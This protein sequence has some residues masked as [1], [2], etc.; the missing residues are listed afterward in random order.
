MEAAA[1]RRGEARQRN[2][3]K[4]HAASAAGPPTPAP[5]PAP[6]PPSGPGLE[7]LAR[8]GL[9]R[10]FKEGIGAGIWRVFDKL[11]F[12]IAYVGTAVSNLAHLVDLN[13]ACR[14]QP[15]SPAA[16]GHP[17]NYGGRALHYPY[18]PIRPHK[19]WKPS[20]QD[21]GFP[22]A[23]DLASD[24]ASFP[25]GE[26]RDALVAAYFC[27]V[28]PFLPVVAEPWFMAAYR[29]PDEPPPLLLF[30]AVLM[31]GAHSCTHPLVARDRH[32]V[33]SIIFRRAALLFH[34]R[35]ETDRAHLMQAA[36]LFTWHVGDGDTITAGPWYWAGIALRIA[37]GMGMH[38]ASP[39]LPQP[40]ASHQR[41]C[42][43]LA[44]ICEVLSALETGR[45]CSI[46]AED[47]DQIMLADDDMTSYP[48]DGLKDYAAAAAAAGTT[49]STA[50]SSAG[51]SPASVAEATSSA[52]A[53]ESG[54]TRR[55]GPNATFLNR[56]VELCYIGLDIL[57]LSAPSQRRIV[58]IESIDVRL[59]LWSLRA[60]IN[61]SPHD[62][63]GDRSGKVAAEAA[64][65]ASGGTH[66]ARP[67]DG[68][69]PRNEVDDDDDDD[70]D[71]VA[72]QC[73]LRMHYNL[74]LLHLHR[75][76]SYTA[77]VTPSSPS[78]CSGAARAIITS[79]ERL[80]TL[81]G[82]LGRCHFS[83]VSAATAAA[84]QTA[85][86]VREAA[87]SRGFIVVMPALEQLARL[88]RVT[89]RLAKHWPNAQAVHDVF[90]ELHHEYETLVT[91]GLRGEE[92]MIRQTQPDWN[93]LLGGLQ[94]ARL[95]GLPTEQEWLNM[96]D[97][98]L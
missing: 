94:V 59:G 51:R 24:V 97:G 83:A 64:A 12:H 63:S 19:S 96:P 42:W 14:P 84:I 8:N 50:T 98:P 55:G 4:T 13:K 89:A 36:L 21:W 7:Q 1:S 30:Q 82:G 11:D 81:R 44:F 58:D 45:P 38:R 10:F 28:H 43:W 46:S 65:A 61:S 31:A 18:P 20:V 70:T 37:C 39:V 9:V 54:S 29:T 16:A 40:E 23:E 52:R 3:N 93:L 25:V 71:A 73:Q 60:G 75:S 74:M 15:L 87:L 2:A 67:G 17:D 27:D 53:G 48:A 22:L 62:D 69:A 57:A 76:Y 85:N 88:L 80:T 92:V 47:T 56:M 91:H 5:G 77:P 41:R 90:Q 34:T 49:A 78:V 79:L 72:E 68:H 95:T 35:H 6:L 33:K 86:E 66:S 26:V 32:A